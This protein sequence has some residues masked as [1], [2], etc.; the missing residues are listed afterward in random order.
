MVGILI[1]NFQPIDCYD[2]NKSS[3]IREN[4]IKL[5]LPEQVIKVIL[6][7]SDNSKLLVRI[8]KIE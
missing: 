6:L 1:Y 5:G 3:S 7:P 2:P 4:F 8:L